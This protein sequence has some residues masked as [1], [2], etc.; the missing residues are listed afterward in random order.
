MA[1]VV[2]GV[3]PGVCGFDCKVT[4]E[5]SEKRSARIKITGSDCTLIQKLDGRLQDISLQDLFIPLTKNPIFM[6]AEGAG[7]HLACPVPVAIVKACEVALE[8]AVPK[9]AAICFLK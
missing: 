9:D 3:N 1:A 2:I 6:A 8:L 4:A 7:C 5:R